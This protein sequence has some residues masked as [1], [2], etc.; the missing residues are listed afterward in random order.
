MTRLHSS[1]NGRDGRDGR[2]GT[3]V[4]A[5]VAPAKLSLR[6]LTV[7][8]SVN[9]LVADTTIR[10]IKTRSRVSIYAVRTYSPGRCNDG[11]M[12]TGAV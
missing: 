11:S 10:Q 9:C 7:V 6:H 12:R 3:G 5:D 2:A 4:M 1:R 8:I